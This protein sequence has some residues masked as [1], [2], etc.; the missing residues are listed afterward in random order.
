MSEPDRKPNGT[1]RD[2]RD[3]S[4]SG[5]IRAVTRGILADQGARRRVMG[6]MILAAAAMLLVGATFASTWLAERPFLF[7]AYWFACAWLTVTSLLLAVLDMLLVRK[8]GQ[9]ARRRLRRDVF[10]KDADDDPPT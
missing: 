5:L 4:R 2:R 7:F 1:A 6:G 9:A 8:A 3:G 10:G